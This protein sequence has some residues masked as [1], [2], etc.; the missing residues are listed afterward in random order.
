MKFRVD[1]L[2]TNK[3]S[4]CKHTDINF[5]IWVIYIQQP[6]NYVI[7]KYITRHEN[8]LGHLAFSQIYI[9]LINTIFVI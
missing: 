6:I 1:I 3:I 4:S 2:T 7:H 9:L 5:Y 8:M